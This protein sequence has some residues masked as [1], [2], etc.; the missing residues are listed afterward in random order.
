MKTK[1]FS[2]DSKVS[3]IT[4]EEFF[5]R[6]NQLTDYSLECFF[7]EEIPIFELYIIIK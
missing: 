3:L 5:E 1:R 2:K 4:I 7:S 6:T